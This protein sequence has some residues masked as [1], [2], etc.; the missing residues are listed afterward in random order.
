MEFNE[1]Q[2]V[3]ISTLSK[4]EARVFI[5]FLD[6]EILR[7]KKDIEDAEKLISHVRDRFNLWPGD[8]L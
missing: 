4:E 6:T 8:Y 2:L 1:Q 3:I 7:H 5:K